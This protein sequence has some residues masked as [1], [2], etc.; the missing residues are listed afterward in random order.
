MMDELE[1]AGSESVLQDCPHITLHDCGV[2]ELASVQCLTNTG[3]DVD[4]IIL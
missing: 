3:E 4:M 2:G 1:C